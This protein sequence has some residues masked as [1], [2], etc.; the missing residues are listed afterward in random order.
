MEATLEQ[1]EQTKKWAS[2]RDAIVSEL[3]INGVENERLSL[4]NK[5]LSKEVNDLEMKKTQLNDDLQKRS[6]LLSDVARNTVE[7]SKLM[8]IKNELNNDILKLQDQAELKTWTAKR[9]AAQAEILELRIIKE[10]LEKTNKELAE[11]CSDLDARINQ[12]TGRIFEL[13]KKE[14]ELPALIS[15]K[16]ADLESRKSTLQ[17]EVNDLDDKIIIMKE[18]KSS[19]EKDISSALSTFNTVKDETLMLE[20]VVDRVTRVSADNTKKID[21]LVDGLAKSLEA[22]IEVNKKNVFE[23]NIVIE[24]LP[25]MLVEIQKRGLVK[26]RI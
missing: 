18:Q 7:N 11:S 5:I 1:Q 9:D 26:H 19:L 21:G 8:A 23:T 17:A 14:E 10:K 16:I 20:K 3:H 13:A 24:K 25:R 4:S 15:R 6:Q 2:E 22:I 12:A